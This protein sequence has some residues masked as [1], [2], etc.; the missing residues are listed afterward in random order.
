MN[1]P[2]STNYKETCFLYLNIFQDFKNNPKEKDNLV[3][4]IVKVLPG[5]YFDSVDNCDLELM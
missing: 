1:A 3:H 5:S 2:E 4:I